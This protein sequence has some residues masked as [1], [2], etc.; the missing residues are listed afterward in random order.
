MR[1]HRGSFANLPWV[2][3][4]VERP[5]DLRLFADWVRRQTD[6]VAFDL[7]TCGLGIYTYGP[8]FIRLAQFGTETEA[9]VIPVEMGPAFGTAVADALRY[10]PRLCGHNLIMFD[11]LAIDHHLGVK[12]EE[13]CPKVTDTMITA[14]LIDPRERDAGGI[15]SGLKPQATKFIDPEAP[16]AQAGLDEL[17]RSLGYT[18]KSGLGWANVP[19]LNEQYTL[20]AGHD[21][22]L[23]ARLLRAHQREMQRL[24]V[25]AALVPYEHNIS[26]QCAIMSRA[27]MIVDHDWT[28][29]LDADLV[30]EREQY[31]E[32]AAR[33]GVEN[34]NSTDQI[35]TALA[36]MGEA[37]TDKTDSGKPK[38]DKS[39]LLRFADLNDKW[40]PLESRSPN[41]LAIAVLHSKRAGKW[42]S[43]YVEQFAKDAD[44]NGRI[45]PGIN[46]LQARTGRMSITRPAVQTLP[47]RNWTIRRCLLAEPGHV[48]LSTDFK[49]VEMRVLAGM[50][51][52]TKMKRAVAAGEDLHDFTARLIYGPNFTKHQRGLGKVVGLAKIFGG[53][54]DTIQRQ[55]GAP[56]EQVREAVEQYDRVYPEI[57]QASNRWQ[58]EAR[59]DGYVTRSATGRRLPLDRSRAYAVVNYRVQSTARDVLGQ[60]MQNC[61]AA[62]LLP[63]M[64]LV[65]HDEILA[66]VPREDAHDL[67][68]E[69]ERC[70]SMDLFGV[71]IEAEAEIGG[72]SWGSLY[73]KTKAGKPDRELLAQSDPLFRERPEL[74]AELM[75]A[76]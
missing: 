9:F 69:F 73:Q 8:G 6:T 62:G 21:V 61:E 55:T 31:V 26:R 75:G 45:H 16:D 28:A 4:V 53:G 71:P 70:M 13:F 10:L 17:F 39:V 19:L 68:R 51:D 41:P 7:E 27:G 30:R 60:A 12:L 15:G 25:R 46:T 2:V 29:E 40:E 66:S 43:A 59:W 64:R 65:I 72:R 14:K 57:R 74:I 54:E 35:A 1:E 18:K 24:N 36:G 63:Y 42:R 23:G 3:N 58:R 38:V 37:W 22:I 47:S 5:E 56:R 52:V 34:V 49:A 33:Y 76:S 48:M 11:G 20:Y 44:S 32:Q 67:A 50:A